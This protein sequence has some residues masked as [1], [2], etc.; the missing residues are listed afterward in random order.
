M[1]DAAPSSPRSFPRP[2]RC[3]FPSRTEAEWALLDVE[4][5]LDEAK[6][7]DL[8]MRLAVMS[9]ERDQFEGPPEEQARL[10][11]TSARPPPDL[12]PISP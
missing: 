12:R 2:S 10:R 4:P 8:L 11:P 1:P 6:A 3:G 7:V 9:A 5:K